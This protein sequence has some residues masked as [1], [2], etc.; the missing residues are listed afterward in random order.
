MTR[1][2][3][4][5]GGPGLLPRVRGGDSADRI[6]QADFPHLGFGQESF[7]VAAIDADRYWPIDGHAAHDARLIAVI[8]DCLVLRRSIVP[9]DNVA[10]GPAPTHHVLRPRH[11][12]L[13]HGKQMTRV[14]RT[15]A[16]CGDRGG[17]DLAQGERR[18]DGRGPDT[19]PGYR[20]ERVGS[21][22]PSG[23]TE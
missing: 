11:V 4:V 20:V 5:L 3:L 9:D 2:D 15:D 1:I 14:R 7:A 17:K 18:S 13:Q 6:G 8:I 12:I 23:A 16:N 10:R 22:A 19:A 21:R